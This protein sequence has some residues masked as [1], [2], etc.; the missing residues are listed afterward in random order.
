MKMAPK[1]TKLTVHEQFWLDVIRQATKGTD[2]PP[3]LHRTQQLRR[4][5]EAD[6]LPCC[7]HFQNG[8]PAGGLA[9]PPGREGEVDAAV[10]PARGES[11]G[12]LPVR[13]TVAKRSDA[14]EA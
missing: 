9:E 3:T 10:H 7:C 13:F 6:V 2:P 1:D 8:T 4:L 14:D 5:F 11:S 12:S